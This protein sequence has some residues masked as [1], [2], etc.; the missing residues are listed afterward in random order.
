MVEPWFIGTVGVMGVIVSSGC[1]AIAR[2]ARGLAFVGVTVEFEP[3]EKGGGMPA[4]V[5]EGIMP[6][7][8][9]PCTLLSSCICAWV[10][11]S[12]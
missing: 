11:F 5:D 4:G 9:F 12:S 2:A 3:E 10:A 1:V 7:S 8:Q 6:L